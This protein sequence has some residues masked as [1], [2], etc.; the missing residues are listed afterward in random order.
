MKKTTGKT[1][2]TGYGK[3]FESSVLLA[4]EQSGASYTFEGMKL[5][6][7]TKNIYKP[8]VVLPN[9]IVI[10][11]KTYLPY[12]EQRKLRAVKES[13]PELDL[14]LLF[15]KPDKKLPNSKLTHGEWATKY[16]FK[17]A[18]EHIPSSWISE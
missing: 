18:T 11:I 10:E 15:E 1:R 8:D 2:F 4:L 5:T 7:I 3:K 9:G 17:W 6:Y 16:G 12:D 14:R 13:H